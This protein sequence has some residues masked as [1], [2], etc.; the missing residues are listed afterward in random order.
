MTETTGLISGKGDGGDN[1][2]KGD[3]PGGGFAYPVARGY[4]RNIENYDQNFCDTSG[5]G[6][7]I[8]CGRGDEHTNG[9]SN[10][11]RF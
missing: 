9:N 8:D 4:G 7:G 10:R 11:I 5:F 3:A 6:Y 2:E 1:Q